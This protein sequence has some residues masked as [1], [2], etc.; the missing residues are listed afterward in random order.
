MSGKRQSWNA[1]A[2]LR[3][4]AAFLPETVAPEVEDFEPACL[5]D[6]VSVEKQIRIGSK[7]KSVRRRFRKNTVAMTALAVLAVLFLFAFLGPL[8]VPYAYDQTDKTA[9]NLPY[10]HFSL[11]DEERINETLRNA[12]AGNRVAVTREQAI[13]EL[14]IRKIPFGYSEGELRRLEA[15]ERVF[16]HIFGTDALGRDYLARV[17]TGTGISLSV[18]LCAALLVMVIGTVY[19]AVSGYAGGRVDEIMMRLVDLIYAVPEVL[20]VLLLVTVLR[21]VLEDF[22]LQ[23]PGG[24]MSALIVRLGPSLFSILLAFALLYWVGTGRIVRAQV[25]SLRRQDYV[26]AARALGAS[27][28]WVIRRHLLP[29]CAGQ[30]VVTTCLQIPS[31]IFLESFLSFLGLGVAAPM[32]SLG[33]LTADALGSIYTA[34]FRLVAPSVILSIMIL[35]FQLVGDGLRDALDPRLRR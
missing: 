3:P 26:L 25:L 21:P 27:P 6:E 4:R 18:G 29:N 14:G 8:F 7:W 12:K 16:P 15:G 22:V 28:W 35:A 19:G 10:W 20:V 30:I 32:T 2:D 5:E 31:A 17:M 1:K 11:Q 33:S 9:G 23:H 34:P 24:G 13:R